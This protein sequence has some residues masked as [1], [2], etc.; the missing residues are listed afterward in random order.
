M[1]N[2]SISFSNTSTRITVEEKELLTSRTI[3][4]KLITLTVPLDGTIKDFIAK[5]NKIIELDDNTYKLLSE[6]AKDP[7]SLDALVNN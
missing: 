2:T 6:I 1:A 5:C 7:A 3:R 4:S